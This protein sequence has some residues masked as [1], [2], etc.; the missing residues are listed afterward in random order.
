MQQIN[1]YQPMFRRQKKVF[2]AVTMLQIMIFFAVTLGG[3]YGYTAASLQPF[4]AELQKTDEQFEKLSR[5]IELHRAQFPEGAKNKLLD[6]EIAR[7]TR[8]LEQRRKLK[9]VL[10]SGS[11][12][13]VLGFSDYFVALARGHVDGAWL[14]GIKI[15]KGGQQIN[16]TGKAI[17]PELI[18][19]YIRRLS[20]TPVFRKRAFN[21]LDLARSEE[22]SDL[23]QFNIATA[24]E[25]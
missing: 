23:I 9:D 12:G 11:F 19:V 7:L 6:A 21:I 13:N 20:E 2:S 1:L 8:E 16:L 17:D 5:Q 3:V 15:G 18:P 22:E 10:S 25:G 4:R 14:T 24:A